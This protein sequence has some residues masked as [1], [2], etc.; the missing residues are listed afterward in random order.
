MGTEKQ[1][2]DGKFIV[3]QEGERIDTG[4]PFN[5]Q[6]EAAAEAEKLKHLQESKG[7]KAPV[8]VKTILHG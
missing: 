2:A 4:G 6:N 1:K 3:V 5:T 7:Q 8:Q